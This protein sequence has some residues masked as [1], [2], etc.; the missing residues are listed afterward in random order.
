MGL[1]KMPQG[2][3]YGVNAGFGEMH[4]TPSMSR[5]GCGAHY[6]LNYPSLMG[7][8]KLGPGAGRREQRDFQTQLQLRLIHGED[9]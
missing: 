5:W 3:S 4:S 6:P 2:G 9:V 7:A 8:W 1:I